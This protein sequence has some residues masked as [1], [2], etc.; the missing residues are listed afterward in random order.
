MAASGLVSLPGMMTGQ[1][2]AGAD[3]MEAVSY[4]I[5]IIL[6]IAAGAGTGSLIAARLTVRQL[7]DERERLRLDHYRDVDSAGNR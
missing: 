2:L 5:L 7:F 1:L 3:P 6:M 4:Q